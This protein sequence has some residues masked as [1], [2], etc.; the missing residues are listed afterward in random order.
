MQFSSVKRVL[1]GLSGC[2]SEPWC[3]CVGW[4]LGGSLEDEGCV[5]SS[6]SGGWVE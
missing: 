5:K 4:C 2:W 1:S 6:F 3:G